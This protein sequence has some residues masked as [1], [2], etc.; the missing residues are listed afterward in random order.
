MYGEMIGQAILSPSRGAPDVGFEKIAA[1]LALLI[2]AILTAKLALRTY[3]LYIHPLKS[4]KGLPEAYVSNNWLY[5]T[6]KNGTA[7]QTFEALHE[8]YNTKALRIGPNELHITDIE[9]YKV[10]YNQSKPF[11][12]HAPFYNGF[13]TPHTVFAELEP[14][15]HKERRRM[16]NPLFSKVGV[17]KLEPLICEKIYRL[18]AKINRL[19]AT[20]EI[21]VYN[22]FRLLTTDIITEFAFAKSANLIE[23]RHDELDSWFL[24]AFDVGSQSVVDTQYSSVLRQIVKILPGAVVKLLNPKLR[25]ILDLQEFAAS[26]MRHW[27]RSSEGSSYPVIFDSLRSISDDAKV[28]EAMD[29]LIAGADTTAS[30]LTT[31]LFHIL[32]NEEIKSRLVQAIDEAMPE[33]GSLISLQALEKVEYLTACVKESLRVGMA[34]P[35]RL[36]R[37][38]PTGDP[39]IVEGKV[40]PPGTIVGISTYTM[41]TSVKAW[42]PNAREFDPDRW[43]GPESKGLE[44]WLCTFS[45]GARMCLGQNVAP[46]EITLAY[47]HIFRNFELSLPEGHVHPRALDRFTLAYQ[48]PGLPVVFRPRR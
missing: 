46:A 34:V 20:K 8:K 48:Q 10:I 36:P 14:R 18:S 7:E 45:K 43:I 39:F 33:P 40:V 35:G 22:A 5:Q 2:L 13:N 38:V 6:I 24:D 41:H 4:F 37:V 25:S 23:E 42:G 27:Q 32:S 15:L 3:R 1:G 44:Q 17:Y 29:I 12:K 9:L 28:F 16:L 19:C 31:G 26:C 11:L 47:A 30:T 21:D